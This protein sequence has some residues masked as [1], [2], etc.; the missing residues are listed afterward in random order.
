MVTPEDIVALAPEF[1]ALLEVDTEQQSITFG[2]ELE[3][4]AFTI[5]FGGEETDPIDFDFTDN[6]LMLAIRELPG[7]GM[8]MVAPIPDGFLVT[9]EGTEGPQELL[10]I[11]T[12]T[13]GIDVSVNRVTAGT[14]PDLLLAAIDFGESMINTKVW[15][16]K[17][18]NGVK[19]LAAH[20]L[21]QLGFGTVS[22]SGDIAGPVTSEKVGDLQRSY[23]ATSISGGSVSDSI[24]NTTRYG[25]L[26]LLLRKTI[27]TTPIV[28]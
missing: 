21:A 15:G 19:L 11:E 18:P 12:N 20:F 17:A 26:Y 23:A 6:D 10:E 24:F 5:S 22:G 2:G 3:S 7:L 27:P 14:V 8:A 28:V 9:L 4:G 16:S 1:S 13:L 25:R